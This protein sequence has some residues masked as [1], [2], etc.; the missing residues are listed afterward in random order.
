MMNPVYKTYFSNNAPARASVEVSKMDK[1][2]LVEID[3]I[4]GV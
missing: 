4:A 3:A 2:A 1:N